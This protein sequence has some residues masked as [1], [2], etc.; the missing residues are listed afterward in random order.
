MKYYLYSSKPLEELQKLVGNDIVYLTNLK[1]VPNGAKIFKNQNQL[2]LH[3][4]N[5][6]DSIA[7]II[8]DTKVRIGSIIR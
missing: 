4:N 3:A 8:V 1:N 2:V 7:L 6:S 5:K